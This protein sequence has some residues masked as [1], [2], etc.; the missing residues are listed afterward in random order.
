KRALS[1]PGQSL[2]AWSAYH[3][4]VWHM[5]KFNADD[6]ARAEAF[7]GRAIELRPEDARAHAGLSFIAFQRAFLHI[8]TDYEGALNK[9]LGLAE[10]SLSLDPREALGHWAMGR[11]LLMFREYDQSIEELE[12]AI[13]L[14][15]NFAGAQFSL[16]RTCFAAGQSERGIR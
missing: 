6:F 1:Q 5:N 7:F 10:Q 2:D 12:N 16:S 15:P 14:N 11:V 8:D 13:D 3:R 9:A 4:G